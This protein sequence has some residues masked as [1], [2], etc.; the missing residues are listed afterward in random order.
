MFRLLSSFGGEPDW[1]PVVLYDA[2]GDDLQEHY[3]YHHPTASS[4]SDGSVPMR[5][6]ASSLSGTETPAVCLNAR[7]TVVAERVP[8][9]SA[10]PEARSRLV[11]ATRGCFS[12]PSLSVIADPLVTPRG[13]VGASFDRPERR[14]ISGCVARHPHIRGRVCVRYVFDI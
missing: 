1:S 12:Y 14:N 9:L 8:G 2:D 5:R 7:T 13:V 6:R 11:S 4:A 3:R 10:E